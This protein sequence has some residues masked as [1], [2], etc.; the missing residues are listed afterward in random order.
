MKNLSFFKSVALSMF[1]FVA[2]TACQKEEQS[3][4]VDIIC[5]VFK[6]TGDYA[7][8]WRLTV[9]N[10]RLTSDAIIHNKKLPGLPHLLEHGHANRDGGRTEGKV[11]IAPVEKILV[12]E[13]ERKLINAVK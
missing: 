6:G 3:N 11:H 7:K 13:F 8:G 12:E 10:K 2:L 9:E 1:M 4:Q 5:K